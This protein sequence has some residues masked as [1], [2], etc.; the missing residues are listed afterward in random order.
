[1]KRG[2]AFDDKRRR[3]RIKGESVERQEMSKNERPENES[4]VHDMYCK[5]TKRCKYYSGKH[6]IG[7]RNCPTFGK[8][9]SACRIMNHFAPPCMAKANV[10]V[11]K[12]DSGID[13]Y[14]LTLD[15][16]LEHEIL[17][18]FCK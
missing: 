10:N 1:M 6:R 11:V 17:C 3:R 14:C 8:R 5:D 16:L 13:E 4:P 9:C 15:S 18:P 12:R 2:K 7:K